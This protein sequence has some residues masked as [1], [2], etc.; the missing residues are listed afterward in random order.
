M[1]TPDC[2]TGPIDRPGRHDIHSTP[3]AVLIFYMSTTH[4]TA[5]PA[6]RQAA[7]GTLQQARLDGRRTSRRHR[8]AIRM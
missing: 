7:K 8:H 1:Q 3:Q 4:Y 2:P 5:T 6:V